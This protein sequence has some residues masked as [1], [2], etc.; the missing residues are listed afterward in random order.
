MHLLLPQIVD[1]FYI[2]LILQEPFTVVMFTLYIGCVICSSVWPFVYCYGSSYVTN[3]ILTLAD[4]V[5]DP[6][7]FELPNELQKYS[8]L[9]IARTQKA[10][11]IK[12]YG[13]VICSVEFFGKVCD[14]R[15]L[16]LFHSFLY[17]SNQ[18]VL[19]YIIYRSS[20]HRAPI[21]LFSG[22]YRNDKNLL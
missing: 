8:I 1:C 5:F 7:C 10:Q 21:M 3:R 2:T 9:I 16:D 17:L 12:G 18:Y 4:E 20:R 22:A 6:V 15:L 13:L 19:A 11:H 14:F